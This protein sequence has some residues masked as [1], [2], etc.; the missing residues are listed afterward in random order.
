MSYASL[1]NVRSQIVTALENAAEA[2]KMRERL[3]EATN[4]CDLKFQDY[5]ELDYGDH[6]FEPSVRSRKFFIEPDRVNSKKGRLA[7]PWPLLAFTSLSI[8][9]NSISSSYVETRDLPT[10]FCALWLTETALYSYTWYSLVESCDLLYATVTGIWGYHRRYADAWQLSGDTIQDAAGINATVT[11]ITVSDADGADYRGYTP[12]FSEGQL[13][14]I[15]DEYMRLIGVDTDTEVLTVIRAQNGTTAA[16]HAK[17]APISIWY[18]EVNIVRETA[19]Q[20]AL[21][22]DRAGAYERK[23]ADGMGG[24]TVYPTDLLDSWVAVLQEYAWK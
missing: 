23:V 13:I 14:K 5:C 17:S 21:M 6:F 4:R 24:E 3:D 8:N 18:P 2:Q 10:P 15:D 22:Y 7:L 11:T 16:A 9:S 1:A 20:A 19:R 12:R